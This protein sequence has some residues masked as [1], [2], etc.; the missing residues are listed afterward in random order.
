MW[1][2][3]E[4]YVGLCRRN[5]RK[6]LRLM[7]RRKTWDVADEPPSVAA[8]IRQLRN[9]VLDL[10]LGNTSNIGALRARLIGAVGLATSQGLYDCV[11]ALVGADEALQ[12]TPP[13]T[14]ALAQHLDRAATTHF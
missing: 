8:L 10:D 6:A 7:E 11:T 1:I 13:D 3:N 9:R 4:A 12:R 2:D 5:A 14:A